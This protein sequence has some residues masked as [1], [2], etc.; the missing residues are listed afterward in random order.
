MGK[1]IIVNVLLS[2]ICVALFGLYAFKATELSTAQD[3]IVAMQTDLTTTQA[4][5]ALTRADLEATNV[6]LTQT[7]SDLADTQKELTGT[8]QQLDAT[9]SELQQ[10]KTNYTS[11]LETLNEEKTHSSQLQAT[12][13]NL[14]ANLD[15]VTSGFGYFS[16]DPTYAQAKA[17]LASDRTDSNPYVDDT[18]VCEDYAYDVVTHALQLKIRCA[19]V[20]IRYPDAAHAIIAFNTTDKGLVYF[21]PQ[22]DEEVRLQIGK[23]FWQSIIVNPGYSYYAPNYDDT[24]ERFN[25]IW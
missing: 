13:T 21:E 7:Q 2:L 11:T 22:S 23:H 12:I 16:K 1:K 3:E 15:A 10:T 5:L 18:Y 14:Q 20:S 4:N 17:F 6:Q 8:S 25:V 9:T 19:F 24:V